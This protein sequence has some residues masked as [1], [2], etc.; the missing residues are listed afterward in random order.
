MQ[1]GSYLCSVLHGWVISPGY[2]PG[3]L[4]TFWVIPA[5]VQWEHSGLVEL[6]SLHANNPVF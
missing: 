1:C 3:G 6:C 2:L 5:V 4:Q